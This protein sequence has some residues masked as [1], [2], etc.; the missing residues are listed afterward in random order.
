MA[1][2]PSPMS[3]WHKCDFVSYFK[4]GTWNWGCGGGG[5]WIQD[6][7]GE[8]WMPLW[9]FKVLFVSLFYRYGCFACMG[10]YVDISA[11]S[12]EARR[13]RWISWN[14]SSRLKVGRRGLQMIHPI[15]NK[16]AEPV[17]NYFRP[18]EQTSLKV[19]KMKNKQ[20]GKKLRIINHGEMQIRTYK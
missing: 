1:D 20:M 19:R 14:W 18:S 12:R 5:V 3:I 4:K 16:Q 17:R 13:G 8:V 15:I 11:V 7:L 6:E 9:F 10:A 2:G